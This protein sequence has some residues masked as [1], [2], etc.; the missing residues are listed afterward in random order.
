MKILPFTKE[1][2]ENG[3]LFLLFVYSKYKNVYI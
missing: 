3:K 2:L 1:F